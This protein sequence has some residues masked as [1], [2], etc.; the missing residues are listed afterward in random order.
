M[1]K[2]EIFQKDCEK[3]EIFDE[4]KEGLISYAKK[5]V[6]FFDSANISI[7]ETSNDCVIMRPSNLMSV[8]I[9]SLESDFKPSIDEK[10]IEDDIEEDIITD[11]E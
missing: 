8:K 5:F 2:I 6:D 3:I 11:E 1:K 9:S 7:L 4:D 10:K